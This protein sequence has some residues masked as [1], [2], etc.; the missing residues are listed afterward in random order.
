[1]HLLVIVMAFRSCEGRELLDSLGAFAVICAAFAHVGV[2]SSDNKVVARVLVLGV[3]EVVA[4][5]SN[6][7]CVLSN[8]FPSDRQGGF[9]FFLGVCLMSGSCT[10]VRGS[11]EKVS[12]KSSRSTEVGLLVGTS[13]GSPVL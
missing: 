2:D 7:L 5:V 12:P 13:T 8:F 3:P 4:Q 11:S 9:L 1:M 6:V 10:T